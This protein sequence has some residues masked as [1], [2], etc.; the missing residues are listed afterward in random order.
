MY[1]I[2]MDDANTLLDQFTVPSNIDELLLTI[3]RA[4]SAGIQD[5]R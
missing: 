4:W 1:S 2:Q 5:R 3:F